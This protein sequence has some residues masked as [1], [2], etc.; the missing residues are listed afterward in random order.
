MIL[1]PMLNP[2]V[3]SSVMGLLGRS[4]SASAAMNT[5]VRVTAHQIKFTILSAAVLTL[6]GAFRAS[7][8][9]TWNRAGAC[10]KFES[11]ST[12]LQEIDGK[13]TSAVILPPGLLSVHTKSMGGTL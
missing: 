12:G 13:I 6:K 10:L 11:G 8:A 9:T 3:F 5:A 2:P 4:S 1:P 7:E